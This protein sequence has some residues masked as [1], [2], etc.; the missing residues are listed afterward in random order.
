MYKSR[1]EFCLKLSP[2]KP[3]LSKRTITTKDELTTKNQ[4][5][6]NKKIKNE[7]EIHLIS[8]IVTDLVPLDSYISARNTKIEN[9][10]SL[11][12]GWINLLLKETFQYSYS[13][14]LFFQSATT[15]CPCFFSHP[16]E[17]KNMNIIHW[18]LL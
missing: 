8:V 1:L 10:M 5:S 13:C 3:F 4:P 2:N 17:Q 16:W 7:N 14:Y 12:E 11:F 9:W 6:K 18:L 15:L